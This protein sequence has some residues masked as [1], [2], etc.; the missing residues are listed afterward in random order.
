MTNSLES[1]TVILWGRQ[2]AWP[3]SLFS[4]VQRWVTWVSGCC[5]IIKWIWK[6]WPGPLPVWIH[7]TFRDWVHLGFRML[8]HHQMNKEVLAGCSPHVDPWHLGT[9]YTW[10][11][12]CSII[13]NEH[14]SLG[15]VFF[16]CGYMWHL[17]TRKR[18]GRAQDHVCLLGAW[19]HQL[20]ATSQRHLENSWLW[21]VCAPGCANWKS[22]SAS[23]TQS[24][25]PL[26]QLQ[27][28]LVIY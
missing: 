25:A 2:Q 5:I 22:P 28:G 18:G 24:L 8:Y 10:L 20:P 19:W 23:G 15:Q 7:M 17:G 4:W 11:S 6:P 27:I 21:H 12:G 1:G 3:W 13:I 14:E 26:E 9:E 16:I